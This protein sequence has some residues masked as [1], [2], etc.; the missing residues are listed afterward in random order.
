MLIDAAPLLS[1][2]EAAAGGGQ[3]V[4]ATSWQA[5]QACNNTV[6]FW[7]TIRLSL[8]VDTIGLFQCSLRF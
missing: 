5:I 6:T 3:N 4:L 2:S 7:A 1:A 8:V